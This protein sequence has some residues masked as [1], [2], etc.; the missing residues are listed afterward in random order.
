MLGIPATAVEGTWRA[1]CGRATAAWG[2]V[3]ARRKLLQ[4]GSLPRR[5]RV[6]VANSLAEPVL[7]WGAEA[8]TLTKAHRETLD[9]SQRR[10]LRSVAQLP[11][12]STEG[13]RQYMHRANEFVLKVFADDAVPFRQW[14]ELLEHRKFTFAGHVVRHDDVVE[15]GNAR[16]SSLLSEILEW[17]CLAWQRGLR[18]RSEEPLHRR[19]RP[20]RWEQELFDWALLRYNTNWMEVARA[21]STAQWSALWP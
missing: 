6:R 17:R 16:F 14:S 15:E 11:R 4:F 13:P 8:L 19:G 5:L 7:T 12:E 18:S 1:A 9:A 20:R 21:T 3:H 2:Y 10:L